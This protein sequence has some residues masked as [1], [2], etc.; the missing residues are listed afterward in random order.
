VTP[1][2]R[3]R[4][5]ERGLAAAICALACGLAFASAAPA[6]CPGDCDGDGRVVIG[7]LVVGVNIALGTLPVTDCEVLD[8]N[9]D[10]QV[11]INE[12]LTAVRAALNAC[13][14]P[15]A[16][17]SST[18]T[19]S[20]TPT[21]TPNLPPVVSPIAIYRTFPGYPIGL[22]LPVSDPEGAALV[23][24][25]TD[26]PVGAGL[27]DET[28]T[29]LWTPAEDQLGAFTIP[30][31]CADDAV[32][33]QVAE[34]EVAIKVSEEDDCA[35][36]TCDPAAGCTS[37]L[38]SVD[39]ECCAAGPVARVA[40]PNIGCPGGLVMFVGR[41]TDGSFGRVQNCDTMRMF[42]TGQ[43]GA[44]L[45]FNLEM[46]CLR[47]TAGLGFRARLENP[48][49]GVV[50]DYETPGLSLFFGER[51]DGFYERLGVAVPIPGA[52]FFDLEESEA[53]LSITLIDADGTELTE[54]L[55][56][57]LSSTPQPQ[58]PNP[59]PTPVP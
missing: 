51:D 17:P 13:P 46:R 27:D 8:T 24:E 15:A 31:A 55:R 48:S 12:L 16:T 29:L 45:R 47:T 9:R 26:P 22:P 20:A 59:D 43:Q 19:P 39:T 34:G 5:L 52:P 37:E 58:L 36:V 21:P 25:L 30:F 2:S 4:R 7:E 41:N 50:F 10:G 11:Q 32:P 44:A 56:V 23:C 18:H 53:N 28:T 14:T 40:E 57:I 1:A 38:P 54:D 35:I 49:R 6:Q 33:S 3:A 42:V